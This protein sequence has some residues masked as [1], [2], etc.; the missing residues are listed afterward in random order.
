MLSLQVGEYS[1][2]TERVIK[3]RKRNWLFLFSEIFKRKGLIVDIFIKK[4]I[5]VLLLLL[6]FRIPPP[7]LPYVLKGTNL[8]HGLDVKV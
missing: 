6:Q 1:G 5:G 3:G 2:K 7:S 4:W 8:R